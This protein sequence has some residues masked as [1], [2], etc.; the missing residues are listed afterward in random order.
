MNE[1]DCLLIEITLSKYLNCSNLAG[2]LVS[3]LSDFTEFTSSYT[4]T[5]KLEIIIELTNANTIDNA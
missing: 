1:L 2:S 4:F 5:K 3:A